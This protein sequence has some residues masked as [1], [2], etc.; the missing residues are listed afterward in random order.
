MDDHHAVWALLGEHQYTEEQARELHRAT[1]DPEA[2][3]RRLTCRV[4]GLPAWRRDCSARA[5][6]EAL[7]VQQVEGD[8]PPNPDDPRAVMIWFSATHDCRQHSDF[9]DPER[10]ENFVRVWAATR[11]V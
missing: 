3:L 1:R 4:C 11:L 2:D 9:G 6:E 5:R 7:K 8:D 10:Y